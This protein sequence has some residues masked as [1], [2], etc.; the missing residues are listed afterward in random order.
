[1]ES[2]ED[3]YL[4]DEEE[5]EKKIIH[6]RAKKGSTKETSKSEKKKTSKQRRYCSSIYFGYQIL[7]HS[8]VKVVCMTL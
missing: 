1:M 3:E 4:S 7:I 6:K 5:L 2:K 8:K